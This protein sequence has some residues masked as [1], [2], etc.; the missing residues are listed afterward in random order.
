MSVVVG[1]DGHVYVIPPSEQY[2][3]GRHPCI[4][5][6]TVTP[7]PTPFRFIKLDAGDE[8]DGENVTKAPD[9]AAS[10]YT[11]VAT[12]EVPKDPVLISDGTT[13][14]RDTACRLFRSPTVPDVC[15]RCR[16]FPNVLAGGRGATCRTYTLGTSFVE[17]DRQILA[18]DVMMRLT[19]VDTGDKRAMTA[20]LKT[21]LIS[22]RPTFLCRR[23]RPDGT[24]WGCP[25]LVDGDDGLMLAC[26]QA[27]RLV[28][29]DADAAEA[30]AALASAWAPEVS[31]HM[32]LDEVLLERG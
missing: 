4:A 14:G 28:S 30:R 23:T 19:D 31:T 18:P 10:R 8:K 29:R 24:H 25:P 22:E 16:A 17:R 1:A 11:D 12:L 5:D 7:S 3:T 13:V 15:L 6:A 21:G 9:G 2:P 26:A 32:Y 27:L 20:L